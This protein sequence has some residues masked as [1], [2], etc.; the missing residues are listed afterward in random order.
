MGDRRRSRSPRR[1]YDDE[2]PD[3]ERDRRSYDMRNGGRDRDRSRERSDRDRSPGGDRFRE[4][5]RSGFDD[6]RGGYQDR[7]FRG[8][9]PPPRGY[10]SRGPPGPPMDRGYG[11]A[12]RFDH[13]GPPGPPPPGRGYDFRGGPPPPSHPYDR[14]GYPPPPP[15]PPRGGDLRGGDWRRDGPGAGRPDAD[16]GMRRD[17]PRGPPPDGDGFRRPDEDRRLNGPSGDRPPPPPATAMEVD[18]AQGVGEKEPAPKKVPLSLEELLKKKTEEKAANDKPVF[19]S[20]E[21][22]AKIALEKRQK[23][24]E[25]MRQKQEDERQARTAFFSESTTQE[26]DNGYGNGGRYDYRGPPDHRGDFGRGGRWE[27]ERGSWERDRGYPGDR[28]GRDSRREEKSDSADPSTAGLDD[29]ELQAIR[30]KY[31]GA[32]KRRRKV[33][34]MNEKKFVF[35]WDTQEDTSVDINPLYAERKEASM[36]GRGLIA[37]IDLKE[38]KKQRA[39]FYDRLMTERRTD[40]EM[41]RAEELVKLEKAKE[42]KTAWDDRHWSE[43]PLTEMKERDW[44]IF[45]EDFNISTKGGNIPDPLRN[46]DESG[47]PTRILGVIRDVGYKEPTPIQRQAIP[48]GL[49]NRDIIGIAETGSGKTASFVIPML[50]FISELPPLTEENQNHGPYALIMA[51]TRELAQQI[52]QETVKFARNL[53]FIVVSIVGGH[54]IEAQAFNLRDGAHIIIATPGRLKDCLDRRILV[55]SQCTYVVMDEADRMIDM[56]FEPDVNYILD[57]LPVSNLKPDTEESEDP[58]L[59]RQAALASDHGPMGRYFRQTVM[60]SATMP[61]AVE[62]LAK[63][64]LRRPAVVTI[65]TAGQV[66]DTIE[67]KVEFISDENKKKSR[68]LE[69]L[70]QFEPPII[71]FVNQKK[72]CDVLSKALEKL[73]YKA[74]TLHGGKS[75]EQREAALAA[76]KTGTKDVLV[77]TDVAGRGID[78]KNVTVVVNYD[79]AKNIEDYTHRIGRTGRAGQK[80]LAITFLSKGDEDVLYDLKQLISK[81]PSSVVPPEL[82]KHEAAQG[83]GP[84][85]KRKHEETIYQS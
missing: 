32:E 81:S 9:P 76:L 70:V 51:P 8:G 84:R 67:Q 30:E 1:R 24:V 50:V 17:G 68:L 28:N 33:R 16:A 40:E 19:L 31:M 42:R 45:K 58:E 29:K 44:R 53:G 74:T 46:W 47:L 7:D 41:G 72:G 60:F 26:R 23:E 36:Y 5:D 3:S 77:A 71:V 13:R 49:Q 6:R 82:A 35:D 37:G 43:K 39:A 18:L 15:G 59:L 2:G 83:K 10:D 34:R 65:G 22:R 21:E 14:R 54:N 78:V 38:Q 52:E 11:G 12:G 27:D 75:Q 25:E 85:A 61:P 20:K 48:I 73:G 62:R 79:M 63:K 80:G 69:I 55:L 4:R 57:A 64:Y 56:G 66:V